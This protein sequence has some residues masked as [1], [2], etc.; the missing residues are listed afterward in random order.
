MPHPEANAVVLAARSKATAVSTG[1]SFDP[2]HP[3][4]SPLLLSSAP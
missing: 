3:V 1:V 2:L 4:F